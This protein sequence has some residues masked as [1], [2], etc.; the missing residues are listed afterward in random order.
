MIKLDKSLILTFAIV[1]LIGFSCD[2]VKEL[3]DIDFNST[4]VKT[5]PVNANSTSGM[6]TSILLDATAD[7]E[8]AKYINNIKGYEITKLQ[9]AI[10]NYKADTEDEIYFTGDLGFGNKNSTQPSSTCSVSD[11]P[12]T[13][14][15]NTGNFEI[16]AC[17][18]L[19]NKL[20]E[21]L[22]SDNAAKI[23][24]TGEFTKAPVSFDLK[25]TVDVK[26]TASPL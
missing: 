23:F 2:E 17:T 13:H 19:L 25:V 8:I 14:W 3:A 15:A 12:V 4:V 16:A 11:L 5:L 20:S 22:K 7:P 24:M 1:I 21:V 6:S 9:F 26:V 10:E 18:N